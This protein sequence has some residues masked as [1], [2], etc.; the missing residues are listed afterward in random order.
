LGPFDT[1]KKSYID[2]EYR[3]PDLFISADF[4]KLFSSWIDIESLET[5]LSF[6]KEYFLLI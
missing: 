2:L 4:T 5:Q 6:G 3:Y 1:F